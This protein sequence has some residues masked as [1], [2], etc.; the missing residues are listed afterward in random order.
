AL[1][2]MSQPIQDLM[3]GI[4]PALD[5]G[6]DEQL[7][8]IQ[9]TRDQILELDP[10]Q[11]EQLFAQLFQQ[12]SIKTFTPP[13]LRNFLDGY[14][15]AIGEEFPRDLYRRVKREIVKYAIISDRVVWDYGDRPYGSFTYEFLTGWRVEG[16]DGIDF[17]GVIDVAK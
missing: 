5:L 16:E 4:L 2:S 12:T 14:N 10:D 3:L 17:Y 9:L 7:Q 8:P 6:V 1:P 13:E 15:E 11:K